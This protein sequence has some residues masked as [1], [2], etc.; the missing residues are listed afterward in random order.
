V[1]ELRDLVVVLGDQ[2]DLQAAAFDG[3]DVDLDA[4]WMAEVAEESTHG[5]SSKPRTTL[6]L[7]AMRHFAQELQ[8]A[9]RRLHYTQLDAAG[10]RG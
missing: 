10:K 9:G 1:P 2:L 3:F 7:S 8:A 4:V 6:F 5:W